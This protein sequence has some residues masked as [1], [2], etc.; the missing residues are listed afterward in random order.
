MQGMFGY[1]PASL[2][3]AVQHYLRLYNEAHGP[4]FVTSQF[5]D[6]KLRKWDAWLTQPQQQDALRAGTS[7]LLI[8][9]VERNR[10]SGLAN[11]T[12]LKT[13]PPDTLD[14]ELANIDGHTGYRRLVSIMLSGVNGTW[15][16][17]S[18][19]CE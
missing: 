5:D 10:I 4:V 18:P 3:E 14:Y 19:G 2:S 17:V 1:T 15:V 12:Y 11:G 16:P 6:E 9:Y 8:L 7:Y 13:M